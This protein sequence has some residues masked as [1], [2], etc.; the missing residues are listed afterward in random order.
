[1]PVLPWL[2]EPLLLARA[3]L[4]VR[5][6]DRTL[7]GHLMGAVTAAMVAAEYPDSVQAL[8]LE[9][10]PLLDRSPRRLKSAGGFCLPRGTFWQG[11][12]RSR[13]LLRPGRGSL[14]CALCLLLSAWPGLMRSSQ[15]GPKRRLSSGPPPILWGVVAATPSHCASIPRSISRWRLDGDAWGSFP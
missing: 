10:P 13:D 9:D 2:I 11:H 14:S 1:M 6:D 8:I 4:G 3:S 12:L 5:A 7:I 15:P